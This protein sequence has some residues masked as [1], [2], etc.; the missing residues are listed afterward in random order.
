MLDEV[1]RAEEALLLAG[2]HDEQHRAL[3]VRPAVVQ[4]L[5]QTDQRR[6]GRRVVERTVVDAVPVARLAHTVA[7]EMRRHHHILMGQHR[8]AAR[9]NGDDVV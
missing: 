7:V 2:R 4:T 1:P 5:S 3:D 8:I 9:Q 6:D